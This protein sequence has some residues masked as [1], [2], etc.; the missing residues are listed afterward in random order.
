M[1]IIT[2]VII[3]KNPAFLYRNNQILKS[4]YRNINKFDQVCNIGNSR[5]IGIKQGR[6]SVSFMIYDGLTRSLSE[7]EVSSFSLKNINGSV[8][9]QYYHDEVNQTLYCVLMRDI[10]DYYLFEIDYRNL[11]INLKKEKIFRHEI[12]DEIQEDTFEVNGIEFKFSFNEKTDS[13]SINKIEDNIFS[14]EIS[15]DSHK[16][17][18]TESHYHNNPE[19]FE[20][21]AA[22][23]T[24]A[25]G[26][27]FSIDDL[28]GIFFHV[29]RNSYL[30]NIISEASEQYLTGLFSIR[31]ILP[32]DGNS[33]GNMDLLM[34]M[35]G[36]RFV[37]SRLLCYDKVNQKILWQKQ[38]ASGLE[39][40]TLVDIDGN[41]D[42]E[43]LLSSYAPQNE[44]P[45]DYL[46]HPESFTNYR[47]FFEII[48]NN[49]E[50]YTIN[51]KDMRFEFEQGF[52]ETIYCHIP[53]IN[54]I[55]LGTDVKYGNKLQPLRILDLNTGEIRDLPDKYHQIIHIEDNGR[56]I[57]VL[58]KE[59]NI[60]KKIVMSYKFEIIKTSAIKLKFSK[61]EYLDS[62]KISGNNYYLFTPL[63]MISED[64]KKII[65]TNFL[66]RIDNHT[67]IGNTIFFIEP[68]QCGN[69]FSS[70]SF[71]RNNR[72]NPY[73]IIVILLEFL[74]I[75]AYLV[76]DQYIRIPVFY[77]NKSYFVLHKLGNKLYHWQIKGKMA[78][79]INLPKKFSSSLEIPLNLLQELTEAPTLIYKKK[80]LFLNFLVYQINTQDI[81]EIIQRISHDL[82]NKILL[83]QL[84]LESVVDN[85]SRKNK[86]QID[87]IFA[88]V[89]SSAITAKTLANLSHIEKL[90]LEEIELYSF[91][92]R[93]VFDHLN[94]PFFDNIILRPAANPVLVKIDENLF[95]IAFENLINNALEEIE[96]SQRIE[97]AISTNLT[98][99]KLIISNPYNDGSRNLQDFAQI[100]YSSKSESSGIGL[101]I[102]E[103][104]IEKHNGSLNYYVDK[105]IFFVEIIMPNIKSDSDF[106]K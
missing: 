70:I 96:A 63:V 60:L 46:T 1:V 27:S 49:G 98:E 56:N 75:S 62:S 91:I 28:Y 86:L 74:L 38:Y 21:Y 64:F 35:G 25:T 20:N 59:G 44:M 92:E 43:I 51:S 55:I 12:Y 89:K 93:L 65:D 101:P 39:N 80:L 57:I 102:S 17:F 2:I 18:I 34:H 81:W 48:K 5:W 95:R 105:D 19:I 84:S 82:K 40:I 104:I 37:H 58:E 72:I 71:T 16:N 31:K 83:T 90:Y 47:T 73:L 94:H 54:F 42:T 100:G 45:L 15:K 106:F 8:N 3:L 41:G 26:S 36:G 9:C 53:Q 23:F 103:V 76:L 13:L 78:D 88:S 85:V 77:P 32:I 22:R 61:F 50:R 79:R 14:V 69:Y 24:R 97:I 30:A 7:L 10:A 33:D 11:Q 29:H 6:R 67:V 99:V 66:S 68:I 4:D 52:H 87:R